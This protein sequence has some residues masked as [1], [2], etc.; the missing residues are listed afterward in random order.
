M[1]VLLRDEITI[2]KFSVTDDDGNSYDVTWNPD[3]NTEEQNHLYYVPE[4]VI[5]DEDGE[6]V[7][8]GCQ[9]YLDIIAAVK[10][11]KSFNNTLTTH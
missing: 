3:D 11:G 9:V 4:F 7:E 6:E 2:Q 8:S 10:N 1:K 5:L